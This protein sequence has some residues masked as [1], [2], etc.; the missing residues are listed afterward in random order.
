MNQN[1]VFRNC[2]Q[3]CFSWKTRHAVLLTWCVFAAMWKGML[4]IETFEGL[5]WHNSARIEI[6]GGHSIAKLLSV[7][8]LGWDSPSFPRT[9][10][11]PP[12]LESRDAKE[13]IFLRLAVSW[14]RQFII[15]SA[16]LLTVSMMVSSST[17]P[18]LFILS[19]T[20]AGRSVSWVRW[21]GSMRTA[22]AEEWA[23]HSNRRK[24]ISVVTGLERWRFSKKLRIVQS[25]DW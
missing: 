18:Q 23:S 6:Y 14:T 24:Q 2:G 7:D 10:E 19:I 15:R 25:K 22:F 20:I 17:L 3:V 21:R 12:V 4:T 8:L 9:T 1:E 13:Q 11:M 5:R 16:F